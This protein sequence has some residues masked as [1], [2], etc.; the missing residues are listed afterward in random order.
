M[1]RV[2]HDRQEDRGRKQNLEKTA[3]LHIT[4]GHICQV[5]EVGADFKYM[6]ILS[7]SA[8]VKH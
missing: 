7:L 4:T 1:H 3:V 2:M 6:Q 5:N 8:P